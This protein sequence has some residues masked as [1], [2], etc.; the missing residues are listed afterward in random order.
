MFLAS[1]L[2]TLGNMPDLRVPSSKMP[3][4]NIS[5]LHGLNSSVSPT[6]MHPLPSDKS[7]HVRERVLNA[8]QVV[9]DMEY[10]GARCV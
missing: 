9:P 5:G 7:N 3:T 2:V 1:H 4:I 6:S 8:E 10:S